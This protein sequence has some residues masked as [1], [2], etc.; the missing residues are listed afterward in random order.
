MASLTKGRPVLHPLDGPVARALVKLTQRPPGEPQPT[1]PELGAALVAQGMVIPRAT[2]RGLLRRLRDAGLIPE[3]NKR[4]L[5]KGA[6]LK[7][8]PPA[9]PGERPG[10]T[11]REQEVVDAYIAHGGGFFSDVA[12]DLGVSRQYVREVITRWKAGQ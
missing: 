6:L 3:G 12:R 7:R 10:L 1:L 4:G 2:M 9:S 11:P 8:Q 5:P